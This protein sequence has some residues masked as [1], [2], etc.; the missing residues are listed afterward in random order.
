MGQTPAR[1]LAGTATPRGFTLVEMMIVITLIVILAAMS[2]PTIMGM[3][4]AGADNQAYNTV[5][6]L[7]TSA[8]AY[9]LKTNN[10]VAV[11]FQMADPNGDSGRVNTYYA[12]IMEY[13]A[14]APVNGIP[15]GG[16][17]LTA[18]GFVV[19]SGFEPVALRNNIVLGQLTAPY[20]DPVKGYN[21]AKLGD[22]DLPNFITFTIVFSPK[23]TVVPNINGRPVCFKTRSDTKSASYFDIGDGSPT[24]IM[25]KAPVRLW[26]LTPSAGDTYTPPMIGTI[27]GV[28]AQQGAR[29]LTIF[30]LTKVEPVDAIK[31]AAYLNA[32]AQFLPVNCYTGQ[33]FQ[34]Q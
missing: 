23:G 29:A 31:R 34:R 27:P 33:L 20:V 9:A 32:N 28:Q 18:G 15:G 17:G 19:A 8:R 30:D 10:Y 21:D 14:T 3:F 22:P 16:N 7:L 1:R 25:A 26:A 4:S 11:H 2:I 24:D 12:A 5:S 13:D 6:S